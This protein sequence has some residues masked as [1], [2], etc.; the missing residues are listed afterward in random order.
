VGV[1]GG[2][3]LEG[4]TGDFLGAPTYFSSYEPAINSGL[5][6]KAGLVIERDEVV[7][8]TEPEGKTPFQWIL[9]HR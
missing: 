2:L 5:V 4:W 1:V 6:R 3:D 7:S 9:A 8:I